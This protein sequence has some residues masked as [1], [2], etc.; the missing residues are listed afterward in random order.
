MLR[1]PRKVL[2]RAA[3]TV[4]RTG[5]ARLRSGCRPWRDLSGGPSHAPLLFEVV[6]P[7]AR[8]EVPVRPRQASA[9]CRSPAAVSATGVGHPVHDNPQ[10]RTTP[11][12]SGRAWP[13]PRAPWPTEPAAVIRAGRPRK[14]P[15]VQDRTG[16]LTLSGRILLQPR[17]DAHFHPGQFT[18]RTRR[19]ISGRLLRCTAHRTSEPP[20]WLVMCHLARLGDSAQRDRLRAHVIG[21][22]AGSAQPTD[23]YRFRCAPRLDAFIAFHAQ[24][25]QP[26][27]LTAKGPV[28]GLNS[29]WSSCRVPPLRLHK[30]GTQKGA[31]S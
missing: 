19:R 13:G 9:A 27:G 17:T 14:D 7:R 3:A 11:R 25:S 4:P 31:L 26:E 6:G 23:G 18:A 22:D 2:S 29:L 20:G 24:T 28:G 21:A 1:L 15:R 8:S 12:W 16:Q 10:D 30:H 5:P